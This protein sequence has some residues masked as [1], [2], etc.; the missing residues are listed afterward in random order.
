MRYLEI[1]RLVAAFSVAPLLSPF[2][3]LFFF[4]GAAPLVLAD[5]D[6]RRELAGAPR[7][8]SLDALALAT[9]ALSGGGFLSGGIFAAREGVGGG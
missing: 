6:L 9:A 3:P 5:V 1:W 8:L 4:A 2:L 7:S